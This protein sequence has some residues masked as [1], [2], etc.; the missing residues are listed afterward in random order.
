MKELR[1]NNSERSVGGIIH[2]FFIYKPCDHA[3][4]IH[5]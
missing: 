4:L 5:Q 1:M 3:I 2:S